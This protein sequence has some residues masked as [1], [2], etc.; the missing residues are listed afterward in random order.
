MTEEISAILW[1]SAMLLLVGMSVVFVFLIMLIG[2]IVLIEKICAKF[3]D[4][5]NDDT[6]TIA[7]ATDAHSQGASTVTPQVVAAITAAVQ[8]HR[9]K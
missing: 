7:P 1:E 2:A 9:K 3:P 5:L 4:E 8:Q 6:A